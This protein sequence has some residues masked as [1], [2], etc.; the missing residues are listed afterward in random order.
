M[1]IVIK[2]Q[3]KEDK[4]RVKRGSKVKREASTG[5]FLVNKER[6]QELREKGFTKGEIH[7][8]VAPARTLSRRKHELTLEESDRVQRLERTLEHAVRVFG[9]K[10]K[11][12]GWL[13]HPNRALKGTRPIEYLI[14]ETGAREIEW[15][16]GRIEHGMFE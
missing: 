12:E 1:T 3:A 10:D 7:Q 16:L 11:A 15:L 14:S 5:Q 8:Y 13:R 2:T 6:L 9:S 4:V